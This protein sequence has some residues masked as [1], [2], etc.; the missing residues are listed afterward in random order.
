MRTIEEITLRDPT[1][2][3]PPREVRVGIV[4]YGT[5]GRA[6]AEILAGHA[7]EI[8]QRT[9]GVSVVV[10]KLCRKSPCASEAGVN[11]IPIVSDWRE[12][13]GIKLPFKAIQLENGMK[14]L[15]VTVS[16]YKINSGLT[17][18]ELSKRP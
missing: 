18:A 6:T 10:T 12:V 9:D 11:G 15:E 4:G 5:V 17:A 2:L 16:E 7:Q 13:V 1:P 3:R 8:R 14:M